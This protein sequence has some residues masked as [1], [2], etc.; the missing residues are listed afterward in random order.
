MKSKY[1][2]LVL[3]F[4]PF[5]LAAQIQSVQYWYDNNF[6]GKI[7]Q[8]AAGNTVEI[9]ELQTA[10]LSEGL[11]TLHIRAKDN[12]DWSVTHSQ[13]FYKLDVSTQMAMSSYE[14]WV[15][16]DFAGRQHGTLSGQAAVINS[17]NL[18]SLAEG[19]HVLHIR[20]I[21]SGGRKSVTH[22]QMF[23]KTTENEGG[24]MALY[25][26]WTDGNFAGR[27]SQNVSGNIVTVRDLNFATLASGLH[28]LSIRAKDAAGR[29]SSVHTQVFYKNELIPDGVNEITAY[30]YWFD[31]DYEGRQKVTLS[32]PIATCE[33][34]AKYELPATLGEGKHA[35][36]IQF[37]DLS[38]KWSVAI[39][40]TFKVVP[41]FSES[42]F[43]ALK[44][45]YCATDGG[46]WLN[47]QANEAVWDTANIAT[48]NDWK[49][50]SI[51]DGRVSG[52]QLPKN[53]LEGK[54]SRSLFSSLPNLITLRLDSNSVNIIDSLPKPVALNI[55]AQ[56]FNIG[57]IEINSATN[58]LA[59]ID[60]LSRYVHSTGQFTANNSF[61][62]KINNVYKT[63]I[64]SSNGT[65]TV[66]STYLK[67]LNT[68]DTISL[69]QYNGDAAGTVYSYIAKFK[70][71]QTIVWTQT[72]AA[73]YGD[74]PVT[75]T[76]T[77]S[78]ELPVVFESGNTDVATVSDNILTVHNAGTS[79]ITAT[80][81]GNDNY[82]A[83]SA[84]TLTL[85]VSKANL[86]VT[87][88]N[89]VREYGEENP[90]L[91]YTVSGFKNGETQDVIDV[92]PSVTTSATP[93]SD[94]G[95]YE[96]TARDADDNNYSFS[97]QNGTLTVDKAALTVTAND[98]TREYGEENPE[99]TYT[100]SGFKNGETQDVIDVLPSVTTAATP[101]SD[102]GTYEITAHDADDNNYSF[103]YQNGTLTVDKAALTVTANEVTRE[104]G[105]ENPELTYTVSG[106]KNGETQDV[107]DVL[108]AVT[109]A[110]TP[111]SD[112]GTYEITA[113]DAD[114]NNYSFSYQNGTLTVDKAALMV[115]ANDATRE[116]GEENPQL[117]YTVSGFKNGETQDVIDVL[118]SVTT[119]ATPASDT[120]TYEITAHDADDNNYS[121]SYQNGTLTV[122]KAA[123]TVTANDATREYGEEN[124][125][126]TYTVSGFKNGEM[127]DVI[128]VLPAVTTAATPASDAGTYEITA[129]DADDNNYSFSYQN[130]T[131]TVDKAAL[132]V[133]A[134]DATR[135]YGE[136]NP[137]LTYTVS[138]FKNGETQDV[139]DV[140]P[141]VTTAA[142]PASDAGT[143]EI[144]ARDADDNNYS[145]SYQNGTLTVGKA[146][147][148]VTANDATR[149]YGEENPELTYTVSGFKNGETQDVIDVLPSVTTSATPASD[150]GT[151]EITAQDADDNNY[152]FSYQNGTL[153]V[154][155]AALIVTANDATREYGEE[156]P[157]LTYT[158]SGFK[159]GET[160]DVID[161]LPAVTTAAT[162]ASDAGTYEVTAHDADDNNYSFSYQNG[163][164]TVGKAALTVTA[165]DATREYGEENPEF[166]LSYSG[167]KN[168]ETEAE[169]DVLPEINCEANE[170]SPAGFYDIVLSGGYDNN[171]AYTL[172]NG[173]L[174][175]MNSEGIEKI[176]SLKIQIFP[177]PVR[178]NLFVKSELPI[179]RIEIY[180]LTGNLMILERVFCE[181]INL[182]TLQTGV[183]MLKLYTDKGMI[184]SK[185]VKE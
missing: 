76:A 153:T 96:I 104:Y 168:N 108:P 159:N 154:D 100:V 91:T 144:T 66:S 97:Y 185:I 78:S 156:N 45:F 37:R 163:T 69:E 28:T 137:Q 94:A 42:E 24:E 180:S 84:V 36:H 32:A 18:A 1:K 35:F 105:E 114:D 77:A 23:Y 63:R 75:L 21:D 175:V 60:S 181:K 134:N 172:V 13:M 102:T 147:L 8:S 44:A 86:N 47:T 162:P 123:L 138:G 106:F 112:A 132:M 15:N 116:Y 11:H 121:F 85:T 59:P 54:I 19:M 83:A 68:G 57:E 143:Y 103:S 55:K 136:E 51:T 80:Q 2:M 14:Y 46:N 95:T 9:T 81:A 71:D 40:D 160:Q 93:A 27:T 146:A 43:E 31:S 41:L 90:E 39:T 164:L 109:T 133:T 176:S 129:H 124:P 73:N 117:T 88:D 141:S 49:G 178:N 34:S 111:A 10:G 119:A 30:H 171:Y 33:L 20:A 151:Y 113:R 64:A 12:A 173:R 22:S 101:A 148:T 61:D 25:E 107:I 99:L 3:A 38:G 98:A 139:I 157:E 74:A 118:P 56:Y 4:L 127:Q 48:V 53:N 87:V 16:D 142:T 149:E 120:G 170:I 130:G 167:F 62:L 92:L 17:L 26:Y 126:L 184:V 183:Y 145:F 65:V 52:I 182:S 150:A 166:T 5:A 131:L 7:T 177:N 161:V 89:K 6:S 155:K 29:W 70:L 115:T 58:W 140:L 158:V 82:N 174:E 128:D 72:L 67:M 152:S 50:L 125:E 165:N 79:V 122:D 179:E 169:L 135:E 110:A